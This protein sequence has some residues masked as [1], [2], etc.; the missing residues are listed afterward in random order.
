[1]SPTRQHKSTRKNR[2]YRNSRAERQPYLWGECHA[3]QE[4]R[5]TLD[6]VVSREVFW[7]RT[8]GNVRVKSDQAHFGPLADE[9]KVYPT[10]DERLRQIPTSSL[11]RVGAKSDGTRCFVRVEDI[12][13]FREGK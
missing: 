10:V 9:L 2:K 1:M 3:R 12:G 7:G 11:E 4:R 13:D 5:C 6:H 8:N